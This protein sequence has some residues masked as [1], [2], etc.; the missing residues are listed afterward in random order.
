MTLTLKSITEETPRTTAQNLEAELAVAAA[1]VRKHSIAS[2]YH[3]GSGHP[4]G[5][6]SCADLLA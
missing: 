3:A 1:Y 5:A 4:G 2:I 6:M